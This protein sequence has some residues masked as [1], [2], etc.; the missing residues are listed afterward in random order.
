MYI[1]RSLE[2]DI[3]K[4]LDIREIIAIVGARQCGKTTLLR[5]IHERLENANFIDFEDRETLNLF[6]EDLSSFIK[7]HVKGFKYIFIDEFQYARKGGKNLKYIFDTEDIKILVSGSSSSE[8]SIQSIKYL[9]GRIFIFQLFP[10]SFTEF[11]SYKDN[12]ISNSIYDNDKHSTPIV[13]KINVYLEEYLIYGGYPRVV[14]S[15]NEDEKKIVLKNIYN[16]YLL[17][18]IKE[19]LGLSQDYKLSRL[20]NALSLQVGGLINFQELSTMTGFK[21]AELMA[22]L[23]ILEKT[24]IT[25][26][27]RP[28]FTNKRIELIKTPKIYFLDNGFRNAVLKNY[29]PLDIRPDS[30][31]LREN[32]AAGEIVKKNINLNY[33]RSKSKAEV[34]FII[35]NQTTTIP[36]EIKSKMLRPVASRS[37]TSFIEKYK[38]ARGYIATESLFGQK[39]IKDTEVYWLPLYKIC[40]II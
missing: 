15:E 12:K 11:L 24:F 21:H 14:L 29:H 22:Y 18:E 23:N 5:H 4:Y 37:F 19:I 30:G 31:C 34:D 6:D 32:F 36:L 25:L 39:E 8:L 13:K 17:K 16:T 35:D 3:L 20:I 9:V 2:D 40:S 10:F 38:P 26:T 27:C 28:F 1:K 33:W 7:L